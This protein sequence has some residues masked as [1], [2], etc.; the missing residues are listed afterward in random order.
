MAKK[1]VKENERLA[2]EILESCVDKKDAQ[3]KRQYN[4]ENILNNSRL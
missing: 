4:I 2:R 3:E 1:E